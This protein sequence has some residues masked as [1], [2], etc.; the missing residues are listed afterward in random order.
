MSGQLFPESLA[1]QVP[2][3]PLVCA[4]SPSRDVTMLPLRQIRRLLLMLLPLMLAMLVWLGV[5]LFR[6]AAH[7]GNGEA[8][9]V[10]WML[11]FVVGLPVTLV[12]LAIAGAVQG[13]AG[14]STIVPFAGEKIPGAGQ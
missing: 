13:H 8:W 1:N 6:A 9:A 3:T 4:A 11:A 14:V 2:S 5:V 12:A 10:A 7:T